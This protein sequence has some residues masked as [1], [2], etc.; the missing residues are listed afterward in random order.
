MGSQ[1]WTQLSDFQMEWK[2]GYVPAVSE[3]WFQRAVTV[4]W[5]SPVELA[6]KGGGLCLRLNSLGTELEIRI[7]AQV[8]CCGSALGRWEVRDTGWGRRRSWKA[9][10]LSWTWTSAWSH[11]NLQSFNCVIDSLRSKGSGNLDHMLI[12]ISL[13]SE[14][15]N[16]SGGFTGERAA[17]SC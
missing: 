16:L 2:G 11:S 13:S 6:P 12:Q 4:L 17:M 1:S 5:V 7:L 9:Y 8:T 3:K 14:K 15:H 10:G